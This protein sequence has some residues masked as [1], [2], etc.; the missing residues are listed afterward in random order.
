MTFEEWYKTAPL[1]KNAEDAFRACWK[2]AFDA[3]YQ[4]GGSAQVQWQDYLDRCDD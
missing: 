4:A 2:A 3:G 1:V